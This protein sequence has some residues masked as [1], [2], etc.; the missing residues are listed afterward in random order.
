M[1]TKW[2]K[3]LLSGFLSLMMLVCLIPTSALAVEAEGT[4][5]PV[6]A[7]YYD[8]YAPG[9][10]KLPKL[11][12]QNPVV[13][14]AAT[15]GQEYT[16]K[17]PSQTEY[18]IGETTYTLER[19]KLIAGGPGGQESQ[20]WNIPL[21]EGASMTME[22]PEE[23][24]IRVAA[25]YYWKVSGDEP[26]DPEEPGGRPGIVTNVINSLERTVAQNESELEEKTQYGMD[27][28]RVESKNDLTLTYS[29]DMDMTKLGS[30]FFG[31]NSWD[32]LLEWYEKIEDKTC[33]DLHFM[34][35][36]SIGL[37][38][39]TL[40]DPESIDLAS[41]M[42]IIDA[43][44]P[45]EIK[46]DVTDPDTGIVYDELTIHCHWDSD[47]AAAAVEKY[48]ENGNIGSNPD[49]PD[50]PID[51]M[52][53]LTGVKVALPADWG[54]DEN[55]NPVDTLVI[56]NHGYVDG[57]VWAQI[58]T[59]EEWVDIDGGEKDDEFVLTTSDKVSLPGLEKSILTKDHG[60]T[61]ASSASA[62]ET[63]YFKLES[64]VP[65]DLKKVIEYT[66]EGD[67]NDI[68]TKGEATQ[69]YTLTFHDQMDNELVDPTNFKITL[70]R[71]GD[72]NNHVL[73]SEEMEKY[74]TWDKVH[75]DCDFELN[76]DLA[77]LYNDHLIN[78]ADM[79]TTGIVVTYEAKLDEKV[80][81]GTFKNE[82][83]VENNF[84][85]ET[86]HD[87]VTVD[88]YQIAV[89]KFE[90][91]N[92]N[93][94]ELAGAHFQLYYDAAATKP[95]YEEDKVTGEDGY[96]YY[97]GLKA[98]TY[99]LK[100][101]KA[102]EGYVCSTEVLEI[103]VPGDNADRDNVVGTSF[104]NSLIPH[105]GGMGTTLFSIVGGVLIAMAG[106]IFVISRRKRRA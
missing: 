61:D 104:A 6:N 88:T 3:R 72:A 76:L 96:A 97:N 35:D 99:Y 94:G 74:V 78:E 57:K 51:P 41:E 31:D 52:I 101:T 89:Y 24:V 12:E 49:Y 20:E 19:V 102:P 33:V 87:V 106:T 28:Y 43:E 2:T 105:T 11:Q 92:P 45:Y 65:E 81:H 68:E 38:Q 58:G 66:G 79:G 54:V 42:F 48:H 46:K 17:L 70:D 5:L 14:D 36:K 9:R 90:Q 16:L 30:S 10:P 25:S 13:L 4:P 18:T 100:E 64:N 98:G 86:S 56:R 34:F 1:K 83:W 22:I 85:W 55:N 60:E 67:H 39:E 95:V 15:P 91:G 84:D 44:N 47:T 50:C 53:K 21:S 69:P 82:A 59:S 23:G 71:V 63:V 27:I 75:A 80:E 29:A 40:I 8:A 37:S 62:G 77:A 73:T 93:E 103:V 32:T 7:T 26:T